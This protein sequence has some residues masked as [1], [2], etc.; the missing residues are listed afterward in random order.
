MLQFFGPAFADIAFRTFLDLLNAVTSDTHC[1]V[2]AALYPES[3]FLIL[4]CMAIVLAN[5]LFVQLRC[6]RAPLKTPQLQYLFWADLML[7]PQL[8]AQA[9]ATEPEVCPFASFVENLV[10]TYLL[11]VIGMLVLRGYNRRR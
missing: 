6:S 10:M 3:L 5:A 7:V 2:A 8:P 9:P 1:L 4:L 11:H